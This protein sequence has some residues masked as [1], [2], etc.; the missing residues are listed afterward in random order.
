MIE[1]TDSYTIPGIINTE[2]VNSADITNDSKFETSYHVSENVAAVYDDTTPT[3]MSLSY[4]SSTTPATSFRGTK[5]NPVCVTYFHGPIHSFSEGAYGNLEEDKKGEI[6]IKHT[7]Y[8]G[9]NKTLFVHIPTIS[10]T[11]NIY[12][13][14]KAAE[15]FQSRGDGEDNPPFT[16][17]DILPRKPFLYYENGTTTSIVIIPTDNTCYIEIPDEYL[18]EFAPASSLS[19]T[20]DDTDRLKYKYSSELPA[21]GTHLLKDEI[22]IDCNPA[23]ASDDTMWAPKGSVAED[24]LDGGAGSADMEAKAKTSAMYVWMVILSILIPLILICCFWYLFKFITRYLKP[25]GS[26]SAG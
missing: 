23:G 20:L 1:Y 19:V 17:N 15:I 2:T 21:Y 22:Y 14:S 24:L 5:Y 9:G 8:Q 11:T 12:G 10:T 6:V 25:T 18:S 4:S 26:A 7:E 16:A 3:L 13:I